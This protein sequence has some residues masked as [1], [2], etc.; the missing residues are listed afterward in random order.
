MPGEQDALDEVKKRILALE[1]RNGEL[2]EV[3]GWRKDHLP[4]LTA[5]VEANKKTL[6][7]LRAQVAD[8]LKRLAPPI[9]PT[10][11]S[12]PGSAAPENVHP[13]MGFFGLP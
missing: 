4:T 8:A 12:T 10:P 11:A 6:H 7:E 9:T 2:L 5:E 13:E 1:E 3:L